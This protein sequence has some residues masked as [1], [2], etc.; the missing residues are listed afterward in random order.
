MAPPAARSAASKLPGDIEVSASSCTMPSLG[1]ASRIASTYS[2]GWAERDD[3]K[4]RARRLLA[5]QHLEPLVLQR[6]LDGAQAV[7]PLGMAGRVR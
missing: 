7:R 6:L 3:L 5:R 4:R 1:E 2:I